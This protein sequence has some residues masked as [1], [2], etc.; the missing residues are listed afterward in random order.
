MEE[1]ATTSYEN[2]F[3]KYGISPKNAAKATGIF[4][5]VSYGW[6]AVLWSF[7]FVVGPSKRIM[8]RIQSAKVQDMYRRATLKAHERA[9][10]VFFLKNV[11]PENRGK[12]GISFV[13]MLIFKIMLAPVSLPLK[14]WLVVKLTKM[15]VGENTEVK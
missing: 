13:E 15:S 12:L 2:R 5:G 6:I 1:S 9:K 10:N 4:L 14:I 7:C 8:T 11:P 3:L